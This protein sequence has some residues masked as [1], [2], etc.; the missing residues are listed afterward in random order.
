MSERIEKLMRDYPQMKTEAR[1]LENQ[2]RDFRGISET[3]MIE[4]MQFSQPES[5][6]VQTSGVSDKTARIAI[7]YRERMERINDE[8]YDYLE[9][10]YVLLS[11]ELR[12]FESAMQSLSGTLSQVMTDMIVSGMTWDDL[13]AKYYVSRTM[14]G[15]YRK[16]AIVEL[17]KLYAARDAEIAAYILK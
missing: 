4:S 10:K 12:F 6:R 16:K 9:K 5:E 11:E 2:I 1:C 13:A 14:I 15:K 3:E 8:W 17:D 7:S